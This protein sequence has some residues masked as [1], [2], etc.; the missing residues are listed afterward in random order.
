MISM[1]RNTLTVYFTL[2]SSAHQD[3]RFE[4]ALTNHNRQTSHI[5]LG[6]DIIKIGIF[7]E[8]LKMIMA[9]NIEQWQGYEST[10]PGV[11][12]KHVQAKWQ[13]EQRK[14]AEK[15]AKSKEVAE[16]ARCHQKRVRKY[17][18]L[19]ALDHACK[20]TPES[21]H[22]TESAKSEDAS[23]RVSHSPSA[24]S[25]APACLHPLTGT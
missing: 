21:S 23:L 4:G 10:Q 16:Y 14:Q 7:F 12:K 8:E 19:P 11:Q 20:H 24:P 6:L 22:L 25:Q 15:E 1:A 13:L 18:S 9:R 3:G 17:A 2:M 5:R